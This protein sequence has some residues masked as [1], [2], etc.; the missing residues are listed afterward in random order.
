MAPEQM[1]NSRDVTEAADLYALGAIL[2]RAVAGEHVFGGISEGKLVRAKLLDDP[3]P[4]S[5]GRTDAMAAGLERVV[6]RAL[7][8][9]PNE[10]YPS[11]DAMAA[12]LVALRD[13]AANAGTSSPPPMKPP[14]PPEL[15][16]DLTA[17]P[18]ELIPRDAMLVSADELIDDEVIDDD[19]PVTERVPGARRLA[20]P[21]PMRFDTLLPPPSVGIQDTQPSAGVYADP[22]EASDATGRRPG[23]LPSLVPIALGISSSPRGPAL[24]HA[25]AGGIAA[26]VVAALMMVAA[27]RVDRSGAQASMGGHARLE[28]MHATGAFAEP[29]R[30]AATA[31]AAAVVEP[32]P[33]VIDTSALP[34]A[35]RPRPKAPRVV[36]P[37]APAPTSR[38]AATAR[39][40]E[41][42]AR[43][44][45][46][47]D[48]LGP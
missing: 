5:T 25:I 46:P 15:D 21:D 6:A 30:R 31:T 7:Q 42:P 4:L 2:Y 32:A 48:D 39:P 37:S 44:P 35:P 19:E 14:P 13:A 40:V 16:D 3:R 38:P 23:T 18:F 26:A 10:R 28:A 11:A 12:E 41:Q 33:I 29:V 45:M 22:V 36:P 8:R 27:V 47:G 43:E 1:L 17:M 34:D 24:Q 9:L 20:G